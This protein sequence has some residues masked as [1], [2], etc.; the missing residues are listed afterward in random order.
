MRLITFT[1]QLASISDSL[2]NSTSNPTATINATELYSP[3]DKLAE[4]TKG[5]MDNA[6]TDSD[7]TSLVTYRKKLVERKKQLK[8]KNKKKL[9]K[10]LDKY[11]KPLPVR[12]TEDRKRE[13]SLE[14]DNISPIV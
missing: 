12:I 6:L 10:R 1:N 14:S 11:D 7:K 5:T 2:S 13:K 9:R 8:S 4:R 3:K